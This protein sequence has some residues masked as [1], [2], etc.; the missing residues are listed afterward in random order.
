MRLIL[1]WSG[2]SITIYLLPPW[3]DHPLFN[4]WAETAKHL[5]Q[6]YSHTNT[7]WHTLTHAGLAAIN[8]WASPS[9]CFS[10]K[11]CLLR[12]KTQLSHSLILYLFGNPASVLQFVALLLQ[13]QAGWVHHGVHCFLLIWFVWIGLLHALFCIRSAKWLRGHQMRPKGSRMATFCRV[14]E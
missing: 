2:G 7:H 8:V 12:V 6:T 14:M 3:R 11:Y 10:Q 9:A 13:N 5:S 1:I 4:L